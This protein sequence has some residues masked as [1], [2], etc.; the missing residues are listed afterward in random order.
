M[1]DTG[2]KAALVSDIDN[3]NRLLLQADRARVSF[4]LILSTAASLSAG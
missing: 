1:F 2:F 3:Y 4:G